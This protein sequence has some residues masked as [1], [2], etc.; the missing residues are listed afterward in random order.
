ML[1]IFCA[2]L[3]ILVLSNLGLAQSPA[4][5]PNPEAKPKLVVICVFDQLRGDYPP[6]WKE[7]FGPGGFRRIMDHGTQFTNCH[8]PYALTVTGPGHA[9]IA[10]GSYPNIHGIIGNDWFDVALGQSVYCASSR[11]YKNFPEKVGENKAG[12]SPERL[13]MPTIGDTLREANGGKSKVISISSKD[14]G[15]ILLAGAKPSGCFWWNTETGL[16]GSSTF[17]GDALPSWVSDWNRDGFA[18]QWV[19]KAWEKFR[20]ELDYSALSGPDDIRGEGEGVGKKQGRVF[21]HP[22]PKDLGKEYFNSVY[23]SPMANEVLLN[24]AFKAI[25]AEN[26]GNQQTTDLLL[27][28]FSS[29]DVVG[30]TWGPDSQEVMDITLRTDDLLARLFNQLDKKVGKGAWSVY[31]SADHGVCPLPEVSLSKGLD[32]G[33]IDPTVLKLTMEK[34]LHEVFGEKDPKVSFFA[35]SLDENLYLNHRYLK[36]RGLEPD[37]VAKELAKWLETQK[38]IQR[39][40][41][42]SEILDSKVEQDALKEMCQKSF[43][44]NRSGDLMLVLKPYWLPSAGTG[45]THGTPHP[46]DTHVP[47][48]ILGAGIPNL[49]SE[50]RVEPQ[51]I[52][53]IISAQLGIPT[54]KGC[55]NGLP[56]AL[57]KK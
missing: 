7:Q 39:V 14:R 56:C 40:F 3:S 57:Q 11:R 9:S 30:H 16:L 34:H 48:M 53:A 1:R 6:R 37:Q 13:L 10:T 27:L 50:E 42:R 49:S 35:G 41:T 38:G 18:K 28:S 8:Y 24:A 32:A 23:S 19:G 45:T 29:N 46:Y 21:P 26:L 2:G 51:H 52:A 25:E 12:G 4:D 31:I 54:P 33:R 17:F 22:F 5:K 20:P 43:H 55:K 36:S 47:L 15:A 44:P